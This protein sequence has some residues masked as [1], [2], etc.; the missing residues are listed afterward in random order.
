LL[1]LQSPFHLSLVFLLWS[2]LSCDSCVEKE[3][4]PDLLGENHN[5]RSGSFPHSS[6]VPQ[7]EITAP[8]AVSLNAWRKS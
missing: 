2:F 5:L 3:M 7:R 8:T 1:P 4:F 6:G